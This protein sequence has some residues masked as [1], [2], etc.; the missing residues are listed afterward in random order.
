[1]TPVHY[2][3]C[4]LSLRRPAEQYDNYRNPPPGRTGLD[5]EGVAESAI[6]RFEVCFDCLWK[7][8]KR[9]LIADF[10]LADPPNNPKP[11]LRLDAEN[12]LLHAGAEQWLR[13]A[14]ARV[15]TTHDYDGE[16]A[17]ACLEIVPDFVED[18]ARLYETMTGE[19]WEWGETGPRGRTPRDGLV[20]PRGA[21]PGGDGLGL[22]FP[23]S[24]NLPPAF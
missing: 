16:K 23:C 1:M 2:S 21:I 7:V 18:A 8:L 4:R 20:A 24:G 14:N 10:G 22:R 17:R 6:Q 5:A 9:H 15:D 11:L 3:K 13:Y 12:G 19:T